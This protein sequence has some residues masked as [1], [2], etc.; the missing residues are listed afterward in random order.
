VFPDLRATNLAISGSTSLQHW[1]KEF[2]RLPGLDSNA[3]VIVTLTTGG[4][5]LIQ[6]YGKEPPRE[7]AMYGASWD[8][9]QPWINNFEARLG[10]M[11]TRLDERYPGRCEVFLANIYDPT[12]GS[13]SMR[14]ARLPDWPDGPRI[15]Q[16]YNEIIA[17]C[18]ASHRNVHLVNLH[19]AFLGHGFRC[20]QFW[21]VHYRRG[22]PHYWYFVNIEDPNERGYDAIRRL[23]LNEMVPALAPRL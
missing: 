12:D 13:G 6:R 17:R 4:N 23:L 22:D 9:A 15:H 10:Q 11:I 8:Q 14:V 16:A 20:A 1:A 5:D 3:L 18:A 2:P 21:S 19:E 7:G